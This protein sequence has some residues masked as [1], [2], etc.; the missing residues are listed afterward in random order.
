[1]M[2]ATAEKKI[3]YVEDSA[4]HRAEHKGML[5]GLSVRSF[6]DDV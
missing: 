1:M 6:H 3:A 4:N 2:L 5:F